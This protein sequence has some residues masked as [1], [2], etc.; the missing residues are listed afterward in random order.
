MFEGTIPQ[1]YKLNLFTDKECFSMLFKILLYWAFMA[2]GIYI[3]FK[4]KL[5]SSQ[6]EGKETLFFKWLLNLSL[7][8]LIF[9]LGVGIGSNHEV[10]QNL[11]HIGFSSVLIGM[12]GLAGSVT[13][14][15]NEWF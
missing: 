2:L 14:W 9:I 4:R 10:I 15:H 3:G 1:L 11:R 13:P 5:L 7:A 8:L 12:S 6:W